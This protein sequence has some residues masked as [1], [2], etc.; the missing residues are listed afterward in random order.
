MP[1]NITGTSVAAS[2][3]SSAAGSTYTM[4][5]AK[6]NVEQQLNNPNPPPTMPSEKRK[7]RKQRKGKRKQRK[8]R[9]H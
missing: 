1:S 9:K 4:V 7:S 2:G 5:N 8:T 6:R 3:A